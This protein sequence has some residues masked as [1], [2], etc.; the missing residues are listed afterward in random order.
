MFLSISYL[1]L[2]LTEFPEYTGIFGRGMKNQLEFKQFH[3]HCKIIRVP[4]KL[5]AV[6]RKGDAFFG[7][8]ASLGATTVHV[9]GDGWMAGWLAGAHDARRTDGGTVRGR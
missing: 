4:I 7:S 8:S 1:I 6:G 3:M 2:N 9:K 5:Q